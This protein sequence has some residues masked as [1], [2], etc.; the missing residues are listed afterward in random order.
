[1]KVGILTDYPSLAV[2]SGPSLHT[3]FLH[4]GLMRRNHEVLLMGPDTTSTAPADDVETFLLDGVPYPSHP[5]VRVVVPRPVE[6]LLRPPKLDII[7]GQVN[8]HV[9]EYANWIRRMYRTAVLNTHIIHLPTHSHFLL[10][11]GLYANGM[12]R[13]LTRQSAHSVERAFARSYNDGDALIVQ[14]RFM[15]DYWRS[16]GV[17]VPIEVVGR[18]IDPAKFSRQ[19]GRD[20]FPA[21]LERGSRLVV[22]CRQD[23][24]KNLELLLDIFDRHIAPSDPAVSL[25]LI[26]HGHT[27]A[28]LVAQATRSRY[29][30]RIF[31]AGEVAHNHLVD[32]YAHADAFVYTS[33]SETFGNVVNEALWCGLPV[34][35]LNDRMGVAHQI[36]DTVNG[37]LIEPDHVDTA[38]RFAETTLTVLRNRALRQRLAHDAIRFAH[39]VSHPDVVLSRFERIYEQAIKRA[40]DCVTEPLSERSVATQRLALAKHVATWARFNY[41]ALGIGSLSKY[42]GHTRPQLADNAIQQAP[43]SAPLEVHQA[44]I[45]RRFPTLELD[46][47]E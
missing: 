31:F 35:A 14:S 9:I 45:E 3:R 25:T 15:V 13:E 5:K 27:H 6:K 44:P 24:E 10:S 36:L 43:Q 8:N 37:F 40:H 11:D 28:S 7:H 33:L 2:Q 38:T 39:R 19:P 21:H 47:A 34:I 16:R 20:P 17:T 46:A 42:I 18:P 22:V 29:A 26:G 4:D 23:R 32:W 1:M 41:L 30:D 12:V